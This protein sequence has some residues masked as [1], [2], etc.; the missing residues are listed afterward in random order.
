MNFVIESE[1]KPKKKKYNIPYHS[2]SFT[3]NP[4]IMPSKP[5]GGGTIPVQVQEQIAIEMTATGTA[6]SLTIAAA[7]VGAAPMTVMHRRQGRKD[8]YEEGQRRQQLMPEEER[9]VLEHCYFYR[10]LGFP[11]T[12]WQ[13]REIATSIV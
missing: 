10:R 12:I 6:P 13:L 4:P 8:R 11:P 1:A 2:I 5:S 3:P 7:M 9:I